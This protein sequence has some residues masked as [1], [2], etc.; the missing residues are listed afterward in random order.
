[1]RSRKGIE[2]NT[3]PTQTS[4]SGI[5]TLDQ[6]FLYKRAGTWAALPGAPTG[7]SASAYGAG[8]VSL[9]WTAPAATGGYSITDYSIQ[10]SSN[11]GSTWSSFSRSASSTTSA[12]LSGLTNGTSYIFRV[13]AVTVLGPGAYSTASSSVTVVS[14]T[15]TAFLLTSGTSYAVPTGATTMKAWAVGQGATASATAGG[16]G[17]TAYK[18]W[19]VSEGQTIAYSVGAGVNQDQGVS[20]TVTFNG[21]TITG[22]GGRWGAA[23]PG[24]SYSGGDGGANG[25]D[26]YYDTN[27][28]WHQTGGA[29]GGNGSVATCGRRSA[30]DVSGLLAAVALAGGSTTE[31]CG[32]TAAFGSGGYT[33]GDANI[34]KA[35]GL[36]GGGGTRN[37]NDPRPTGA[38][39]LYFT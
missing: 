3:T 17:G 33:D 27:A 11:S 10:Y 34:W 32:A 30:T 9:T 28:D 14:F 24:G 18:T 20:S 22:F 2:G 23:R 7:L 12:S 5:W 13:A 6:L 36:G 4:A 16:A 21:T 19:S 31:A 1:M 39:V 37:W 26:G 15:P 8:L 38:V 35:A 25:G 29:V